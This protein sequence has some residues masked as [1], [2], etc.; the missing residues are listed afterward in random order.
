MYNE[1]DQTNIFSGVPY[2]SA[3]HL[4]FL[5]SRR[6]KRKPCDYGL[7]LIL[8]FL[9]YFAVMRMLFFA[10]HLHIFLFVSQP[11]SYCFFVFS[12]NLSDFLH[13]HPFLVKFF[14]CFLGFFYFTSSLASQF[15]FLN[16][17]LNK[18]L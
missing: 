8:T 13:R 15:T 7:R 18:F 11:V 12:E 6:T 14:C 17:F 10:S 2:I 3:I 1:S 9:D 5:F 4:Y 16:K